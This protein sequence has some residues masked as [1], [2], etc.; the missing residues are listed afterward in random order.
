MAERIENVLGNELAGPAG[1]Q[2]AA[3]GMRRKKIAKQK[4]LPKKNQ[5]LRELNYQGPA[6]L[7]SPEEQN[8]AGQE[9]RKNR[10]LDML[11]NFGLRGGGQKESIQ[12]KQKEWERQ[13]ED[14]YKRIESLKSTRGRVKE[15]VKVGFEARGAI[16]E[17][18][19]TG[20]IFIV[21]LLLSLFKDFSDILDLGT[22]GT[23]INIPVTIALFIT[24]W[25]MGQT[26]RKFVIK[27]FIGAIILEFIP[28]LNIIPL[29][30]ILTLWMRIKSDNDKAK[31]DN[32]RKEE[33]RQIK[34]QIE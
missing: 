34:N 23:I 32:Q 2:L 11:G 29:Y 25:G 14:A 1:Q 5:G 26:I 4:I 10:T 21:T 9:L 8:Q 12:D 28:F 17:K 16:A 27:R 33:E 30:T 3:R 22:L 19:F 7:E 24:F 13:A 6:Y 20:G 18:R 31:E 15:G